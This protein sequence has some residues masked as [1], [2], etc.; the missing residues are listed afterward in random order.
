[1]SST[2]TAWGTGDLEIKG[3]DGEGEGSEGEGE[4][5]GGGGEGGG[6]SGEVGGSKGD[7]GG[8]EGEGSEGGGEGDGPPPHMRLLAQDEEVEDAHGRG[9]QNW[10]EVLPHVLVS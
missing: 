10:L 1:M 5:E 8:G 2:G 7:G 9:H 3:G 4:A 6:G